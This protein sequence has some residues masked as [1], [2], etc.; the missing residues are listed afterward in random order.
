M[1]QKF[2]ATLTIVSTIHAPTMIRGKPSLFSSWTITVSI[3]KKYVPGI[4]QAKGAAAGRKFR[5]NVIE[6]IGPAANAAITTTGNISTAV[7]NTALFAN[8]TLS[9]FLFVAESLG[10]KSD[11]T[12]TGNIMVFSARTWLIE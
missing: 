11:P 7:T 9:S 8:R 2:T 10:N 3:P 6:M 12:T 5:P 4:S 1:A